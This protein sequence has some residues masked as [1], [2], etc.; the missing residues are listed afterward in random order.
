[1]REGGRTGALDVEEVDVV[2]TSVHG[3]PERQCVRDLP[4]EPDVL[5]RGEQPGELGPDDTD[6]VTQ[7]GEQNTSR[8]EG[9]GQASTAGHPDGPSQGIERGQLLVRFL[10]TNNEPCGMSG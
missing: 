2:R 4:V 10:H 8:E 6:D 9:E 7:H 5:V 1:M 3:G